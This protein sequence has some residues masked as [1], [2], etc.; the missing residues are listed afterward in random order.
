MRMRFFLRK[1]LFQKPM[2]QESL[3]QDCLD[4]DCLKGLKQTIINPQI[5][6]TL[7]IRVAL[8]ETVL[9]DP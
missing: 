3:D 2:I 6:I 9:I 5:I 8:N 7:H 4:Q 1:T